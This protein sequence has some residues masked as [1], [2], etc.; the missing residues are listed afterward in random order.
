VSTVTSLRKRAA[1]AP[2]ADGQ[3]EPDSE[4]QDNPEQPAAQAG[5]PTYACTRC[6]QHFVAGEWFCADGERHTVAEL[7]YLLNDAPQ[8]SG[9]DESG[10]LPK[11]GRTLI[12]NVPPPTWEL[13]EDQHDG[14][15]VVFE[16]GRYATTD[17]VVQYYLGLRGGYC[18]EPEWEASW[19]SPEEFKLRR[20][21]RV[22]RELA[23]RE[24]ELDELRRQLMEG[25]N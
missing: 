16:N 18:T 20:H 22:E 17:P 9:R 11:T 14:G 10:P 8:Q 23:A 15:T 6:G 19:L 21:E 25:S 4:R 2:A 3:R 13:G 1:R 12:S 7:T 24:K 5:E